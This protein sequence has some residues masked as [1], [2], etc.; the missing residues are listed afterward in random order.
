MEIICLFCGV[1][2]LRIKALMHTHIHTHTRFTF[3]LWT[4]HLRFCKKLGAHF[5]QVSLAY[6]CPV[7]IGQTCENVDKNRVGDSTPHL[8]ARIPKYHT[9]TFDG[10]PKE[11]KRMIPK[12]CF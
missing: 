2:D 9:H 10:L 6:L 5:C 12:V 7:Y 8:Y 3:M 4:P 11:L 1:P